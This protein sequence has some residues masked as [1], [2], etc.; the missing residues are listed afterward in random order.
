MTKGGDG[1]ERGLQVTGRG[2]ETGA[3][4]KKEDSRTAPRLNFRGVGDDRV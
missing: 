1:E 4:E 3:E 2:W